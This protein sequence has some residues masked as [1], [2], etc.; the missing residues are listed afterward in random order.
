MERI[1]P[2]AIMS[3]I[4]AAAFAPVRAAGTCGVPGRGFQSC[5]KVCSIRENMK[6]QQLFSA[7]IV[8]EKHLSGYITNHRG[9][10]SRKGETPVEFISDNVQAMR[11]GSGAAA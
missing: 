6:K 7:N 9:F 2:F 4:Q 3:C 8:E 5:A 10:L 1:V 11:D